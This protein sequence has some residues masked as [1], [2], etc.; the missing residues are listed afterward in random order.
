MAT[1]ILPSVCTMD[2]P[3]TCSL[4]V[5]VQDGRVTAIRGS[6]KNPLTNGFICSKV[7][8]FTKRLYAADRLLHPM[9]RTG[10]KGSREFEAIRWDEAVE[11]ICSRFKQIKEE[12]G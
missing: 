10:E 1:Q 12:F 11:M 2:C 4:D 3:D 8:S 9:K 6:H 7:G 5:E